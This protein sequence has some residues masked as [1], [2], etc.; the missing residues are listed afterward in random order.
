MERPLVC[1]GALVQGPSQKFLIV[2]TT[3]W[4]GLWGVPGG[5]VEWGE[6]AVSAVK[7]EFLEEV[8][9][10]L[11][12]VH[13]VHVQEAILSPEFFKESHMI[14]MDFVA[15]TNQSEVVYNEEI[16]QHAWVTLQEARTHPLNSFT[17]KLLDAAEAL[18]EVAR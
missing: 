13:F 9:L 17:L 5:K 10:E 14:L 12:D 16:L 6:D 2:Q 7:R 11:F 1:V 8:G 3:K 18:Q 4:R 15:K